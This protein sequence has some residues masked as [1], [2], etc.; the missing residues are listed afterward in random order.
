MVKRF[1]R[2]LEAAIRCHQHD[3]WTSVLPRVLFEIR[4]AWR[5]DLKTTSAQLV[6]GQHLR[7]PGE[8]IEKTSENIE[9]AVF[10]RHLRFHFC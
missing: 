1:H 2:Q 10:I 8:F 9:P 5:E 3:Q 6:Y 7:L 4:A